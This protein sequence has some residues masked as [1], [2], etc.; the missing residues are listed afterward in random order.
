MASLLQSFLSPGRIF[1]T[2]NGVLVAA[3][4]FLADYNEVS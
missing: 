4:A 1:L 3:G 2:A